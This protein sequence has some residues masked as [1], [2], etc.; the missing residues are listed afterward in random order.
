MKLLKTLYVMLFMMIASS[1]QSTQNPIKFLTDP[2]LQTP[3]QSAVH[4][5]WFTE[6]QGD[7]HWVE[8]GPDLQYK[9][10]ANSKLMSR[11]RHEIKDE[12]KNLIKNENSNVWRHEA[13]ISDL[14]NHDRLPYR[15][16]T[17]SN[18]TFI[19][20]S[21]FSFA[22][23]PAAEKPLKI[24]LT[25]D[26]QLKPMVA[27][28]LQK[29]AE[30][31]G[32]FDAVFF[33]G[34]LV[35]IPDGFED[36][37]SSPKSFFAC[38]QGH[39][40][41]VFGTT[42]YVGASIIQN[43]PIFPAIGNHDVMGRYSLDGDLLS[44]FKNPY[45]RESVQKHF[46]DASPEELKNLSFNS[47]T[48]EE[49]FSL[50]LNPAGNNTY[51]AITVGDVRLVT[52]YATRIWRSGLTTPTLR[53][54]YQESV[55]TLTHPEKWGHGDFI[56]EPLEKGS[57]QYEWLVKELE[58]DEFKNA[59][60]KV[61][62]LHNPLHTLGENAIPPYCDPIQTIHNDSNG[63]I[64]NVTYEYPM[65]ND[66]LIRDIEPL[67][68]KHG[69]DLVFFGHSH[70]WNRFESSGGMAYLETSNVGN[71]YG[72]YTS[73][74]GIKR[75]T[76]VPAPN[77]P[78]YAELEDPNGLEPV[79]PT[80]APLENDQGKKLPFISSNT[81]SVFSVLDTGTRSIDSYYFDT[82]HPEKGV[83]KFDTFKLRE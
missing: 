28:N 37:F 15:V 5:I 22:P 30:T 53:G 36:W 58:S 66:V 40:N 1:A 7:Q 52:L 71:S 76:M 82:E 3:T 20:S 78:D 57:P 77:L 72:A 56:F 39:A 16:V 17:A 27:A 83:I 9:T 34:D 50:P 49:M 81:I 29:A 23:L 42:Q 51:Y 2:F 21:T 10:M 75:D 62:M 19:T 4:V 48:Y 24:L 13:I 31:I 32:A 69:V 68:E 80:I 60:I 11:I 38:L 61:V 35:E 46:P 44:Q 25:S 59:K 79:M 26:H 18:D 64:T 63:N 12:A 65:A 55:D 45:P 14:S 73:L 47:D 54:K 8:W 33:A 41:T 43:A 6:F 74:N 67:L 70:I